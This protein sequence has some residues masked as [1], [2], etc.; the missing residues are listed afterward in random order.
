MQL[1]DIT[2]GYEVRDSVQLTKGAYGKEW[3]KPTLC[4]MNS[5]AI[6]F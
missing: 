3:V 6:L 4:S 5:T 2:D 1:T